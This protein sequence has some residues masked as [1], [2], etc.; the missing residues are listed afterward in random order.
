MATGRRPSGDKETLWWN[1]KVQE[2]ITANTVAK[3][4]WNA[5]RRQEDKDRYMQANKATKK[6]VATTN[7]LAMSELDDELETP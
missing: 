4:L 1:D 5:S 2:V 3:K 7:A 6:A